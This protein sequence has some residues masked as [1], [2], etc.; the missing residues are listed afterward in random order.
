MGKFGDW[1]N[2]TSDYLRIEP[3]TQMEVQWTGEALKAKNTFGNEGWEFQFQ[4]DFGVKSYFLGNQS[5]VAR[6]D[7]YAAGDKL[8]IKRT[9]KD[10]SGKT[11]ITVF[12][13]GEEAPF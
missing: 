13:E 8:I 4:T 11:K 1:A 5:V 12:K 9:A 7:N 2:E 6:F 10:A 3:G